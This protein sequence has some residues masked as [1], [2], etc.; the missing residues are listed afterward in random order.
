MKRANGIILTLALLMV[1]QLVSAQSKVKGTL[2]ND[3]HTMEWSVSGITVTK[4]GQPKFEKVNFAGTNDGSI[5]QEIEGTVSP[6]TTI[7]ADLKKVSGKKMPKIFIDFD[8][9]KTGDP[10]FMPGH[11]IQLEDKDYMSKSFTVPSNAETVDIFIT[12]RTPDPQPRAYALEMNVSIRLKVK[13]GT[14]ATPVRPSAPVKKDTCRMKK[15]KYEFF[16]LWGEVSIRCNDEED[17]AYEFARLDDPI[18]EN[19]RI[20]TK[21]D[22]GAVLVWELDDD[23]NPY[24]NQTLTIGEESVIVIPIK[25]RDPCVVRNYED[26]TINWGYVAG[27]A[28]ALQKYNFKRMLEGRELGDPC[29]KEVWFMMGVRDLDVLPPGFDK[30]KIRMHYK[31]LSLEQV[32]KIKRSIMLWNDHNNP[33]FQNKGTTTEI[34]VV[35]AIESQG[36]EVKINMLSGFMPIVSEKTKA[37]HILNQGQSATVGRNGK[38][39]VKKID[40]NKVAKKFGISNAAL[41]GN[42]ETVVKRYEIERAIVKYKVTKGDHQGVLAKAFDKY[43]RYER[44]ELKIGNVETIALTQGNTSYA[45]NKNK[46]TAKRTKDADLNFLNLNETLMKKL[47]LK[48]KGTATVMG[49]QCDHYVGT[50]V[51]YY[52][53]KGLVM[54]KVQKEKNG[55]TTIHEV[56]SIEQPASIDAKMFKMPDGYTVK[57]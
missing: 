24:Q 49:K 18:Y 53:W 23:E 36:S 54:K 48:K 35:Y 50:N 42:T 7:T 46:K 43:G 26:G 13:G 37:F 15:S 1:A 8:Y 19:D 4:K 11:L 34:P 51:E 10:I 52:V 45:L 56:T 55:A 28:W 31:E 38:I 22:S 9:R 44:R 2:K 30:E 6:G 33:A 21:E 39:V 40:V 25:P 41:Q 12:Y 5:K 32:I 27:K 47:N 14:T 57:K 3:G 16:D 29:E 20:R 17:D